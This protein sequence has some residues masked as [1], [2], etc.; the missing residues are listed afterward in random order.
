M[1]RS[2]VLAFTGL[3]LALTLWFLYE[4]TP[5]AKMQEG[6]PVKETSSGPHKE[7]LLKDFL[8]EIN[9]NVAPGSILQ[10][11]AEFD[12]EFEDP[13]LPP[14]MGGLIDKEAY[15]RLRGDYIDMLRGRPSVEADE[16]RTEALQTLARQESIA[17]RS[18]SLVAG[19]DETNW[20]FI[21]PAPIPQGQTQ[22]G[23]RVPVS[24]R[25]IAIAVHP[26]DPDTV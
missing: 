10:P 26:T 4:K 13:D 5:T 3:V 7:I 25:T 12:E 8:S 1:K 22:T 14:G 21:G 18:Q 2:R 15:L 19:A 16:L 6:G 9:K 24:G 20:Q 17:Q 11:G 23:A